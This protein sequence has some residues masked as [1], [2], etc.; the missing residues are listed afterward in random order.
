MEPLTSNKGC[1]NQRTGMLQRWEVK[2]EAPTGSIEAA[3]KF[4]HQK[5]MTRKRW[6]I[7]QGRRFSK[8]LDS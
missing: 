1:S 4:L 3:E 5:R 7:A 2:R 6:G 8:G